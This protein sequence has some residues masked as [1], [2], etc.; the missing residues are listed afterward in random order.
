MFYGNQWYTCTHAKTMYNV[1]SHN[2]LP[3]SAILALGLLKK[4]GKRK[5]DDEQLC[6]GGKKCFFLVSCTL[7]AYFGSLKVATNV[8]TTA[9]NAYIIKS[10]CRY[11]TAKKN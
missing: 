7:Q 6:M 2:S 4:E 11:E 5:K 1:C 8:D 3:T 9:E 10:A